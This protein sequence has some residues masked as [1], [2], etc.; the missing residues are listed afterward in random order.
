MEQAEAQ[1]S[2]TSHVEDHLTRANR[3]RVDDCPAETLVRARHPI[4]G[5]GILEDMREWGFPVT[6]EQ[7]IAYTN[8]YWSWAAA[9]GP[10]GQCGTH[11]GGRLLGG[12]SAVPE[13][14]VAGRAATGA[15]DMPVLPISAIPIEL[16]IKSRACML[17]AC[18]GERRRSSVATR[19]P[20]PVNGRCWRGGWIF[21]ARHC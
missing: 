15:V 16:V 17:G 6:P 2:P 12:L 9:P 8:A 11:R 18:R 7:S 3:K 20:S 19:L 14:R 21:T 4:V 13:R 10:Q 5:T 1:P